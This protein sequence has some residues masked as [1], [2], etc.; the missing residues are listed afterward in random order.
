M[1]RSFKKAPVV[2]TAKVASEKE[3][4]QIAHRRERHDVKIQLSQGSDDV[5]PHFHPH[6][7]SEQ[8]SKDGKKWL[9]DP[10]PRDLRK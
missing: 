7:G 2:P 10:D 9:D 4:K 3:D 8:F 1:S 5:D 6:S